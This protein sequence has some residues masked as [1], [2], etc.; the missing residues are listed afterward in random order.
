MTNTKDL[1]LALAEKLAAKAKIN[2]MVRFSDQNAECF[3]RDQVAVLAEAR[4]AHKT[5]ANYT[6]IT[7]R[8]YQDDK[9]KSG[10]AV[11][12]K[13]GLRSQISRILFENQNI[14]GPKGKLP[15]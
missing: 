4:L 15:A 6:V 5:F 7:N 1:R 11:M 13:S 9:V 8:A 12:L 10:V 3:V 14:I 2:D